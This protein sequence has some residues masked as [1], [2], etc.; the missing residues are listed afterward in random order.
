MVT[1]WHKRP[2]HKSHVRQF[3]QNWVGCG[4][5]VAVTGP[6]GGG[7]GSTSYVL[8][9]RYVPRER[10]PFSTLNF[11]SGAKNILFQSITIFSCKANFNCFQNVFPF[12]PFIHDH[13]WPVR[14][15]SIGNAC[16]FSTIS[17]SRGPHSN[18]VSS[19][20]QYYFWR[21]PIF[22][23]KL[24]LEPLMFH[25][26]RAHSYTKMWGEG[27]LP[28]PPRVTG[29]MSHSFLWAEIASLCGPL[30]WDKYMWRCDR[31]RT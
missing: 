9:I 27:P 12:M 15:P 5:L 1:P 19:S 7:G 23:L 10:P 29:S 30:I 4:Y 8:H 25:F 18:K 17:S 6:G 20:V 31:G 2:S 13:P 14:H 28:P 11:S 3:L 24:I 21:T 22:T 16:A 26:A